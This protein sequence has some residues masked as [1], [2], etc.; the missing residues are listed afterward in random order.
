MHPSTRKELA[1]VVALGGEHSSAKQRSTR[2][3]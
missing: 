2:A 3:H 1:Y